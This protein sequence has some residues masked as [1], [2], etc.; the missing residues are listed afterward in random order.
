MQFQVAKNGCKC[1]YEVVL[2]TD[3]SF[4]LVHETDMLKS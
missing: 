4:M 1:S 2:V 3:Y